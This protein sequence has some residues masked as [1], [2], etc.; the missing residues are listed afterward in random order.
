MKLTVLVA[1]LT[2]TASA[3]T[4]TRY[5]PIAWSNEVSGKNFPLFALID[6]DKAA[7]S[8]ISSSSELRAALDAKRKAV[9]EATSSCAAVAACHVA[10]LSWSPDDIARVRD[11]LGALAKSGAL[12]S[13]I[14]SMRSSGLFARDADLDDQAFVARSWERAAGGVNN[15]LAVYGKGDKPRY[16]AIDSVAVDATTPGYGRLVDTAMGLM[17]EQAEKWDTFYQ[18]SL[19]LALRLLDINWRD[20][21][22][23]LE[24][25]HLGENVAAYKRV[26]NVKWAEFPYTVALV[27]GAGLSDDMEKENHAISPMGKQIIE[28]AARRY[29]AHKVAFIIVSGGYVHP[30]YTRFAEA[31]EMKRA[32]M[33]DFKVPED[34]I[35]IDPHARHTTTNIRNAARLMFR[36]GIPTDRPALITTQ[37]YHLDSIAAPTFD[38]RNELELGYRPYTSKKRLSRFELEWLPNVL[39]LH[40]DPM[41]PLDP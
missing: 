27:P 18:P 13:L 20:E 4:A 2:L 3:S 24:P 10:A 30:K 17:S 21:A 11:A 23:R 36:Y 16:P 40:A 32:L 35:L 34:A 26:A 33:R 39:S 8:T 22:G 14:A 9:A 19:A 28:I 15:V 25:M 31:V 12:K 7:L 6:A 5:Q 37:S 1:L 29:F 38:E 41:D